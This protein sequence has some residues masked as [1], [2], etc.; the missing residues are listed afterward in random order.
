MNQQLLLPQLFPLSLN[1]YQLHKAQ[2]P[3]WSPG[4]PHFTATSIATEWERRVPGHSQKHGPLSRTK[5]EKRSLFAL[6]N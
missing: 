1:L 2:I 3:P 6:E 5:L 4:L